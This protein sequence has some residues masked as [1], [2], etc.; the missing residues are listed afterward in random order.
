MT[1]CDT[2]CSA[3]VVA[4]A[5]VTLFFPRSWRRSRPGPFSVSVFS[6]C[7]AF[8]M[9]KSLLVLLS[10]P[11]VNKMTWAFFFYLAA[12]LPS[13]Q[14]AVQFSF[15]LKYGRNQR[16]TARE[17]RSKL[18]SGAFRKFFGTPAAANFGRKTFTGHAKHEQIVNFIDHKFWCYVALNWRFHPLPTRGPVRK[19]KKIL[20]PE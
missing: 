1:M 20:R 13:C 7:V 19:L 10:R 4:F 12:E 14:A 9:V 16:R 5:S 2:Y 15:S 6:N 17:S 18:A 3:S 8:W 11:C